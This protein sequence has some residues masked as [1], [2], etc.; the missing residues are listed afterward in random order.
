MKLN[1]TLFGLDTG[2]NR[3][4][5]SWASELSK[6]FAI[7]VRSFPHTLFVLAGN[8]LNA[9]GNLFPALVVVDLGI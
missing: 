3:R 2:N 1:C 6:V 8:I 5:F 9:G 4:I 7:A